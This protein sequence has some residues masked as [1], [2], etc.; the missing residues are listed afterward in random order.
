MISLRE[1][2]TARYRVSGHTALS[3]GGGDD[4]KA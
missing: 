4:V 2:G 3:L 1:P